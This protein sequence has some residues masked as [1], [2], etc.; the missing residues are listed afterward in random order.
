MFSLVSFQMVFLTM[1]CQQFD[2][3][4][5]AEF[6]TPCLQLESRVIGRWYHRWNLVVYT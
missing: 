5:L 6:C 2:Y 4:A 1:W 3:W